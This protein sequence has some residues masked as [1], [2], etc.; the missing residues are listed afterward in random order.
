MT[1]DS[2][3]RETALKERVVFVVGREIV[4]GDRVITIVLSD[5]FHK[6]LYCNF[7]RF[8]SIVQGLTHIREAVY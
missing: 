6:K 2:K 5:S 1:T 8:F 3:V 4:E 7:D